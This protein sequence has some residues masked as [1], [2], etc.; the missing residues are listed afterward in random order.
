MNKYET[1]FIMS[2]KITEE[3]KANVIAKITKLISED[4]IIISQEDVG[5]K[6]LA[7]QIHKHTHANYYI[8][9]FESDSSFIRELERNYRIIEEILK[10]IIIRRD[11]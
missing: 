11:N 4:G 9:N 10:F 1:V 8:I 3:Q 6:K 2:N 7:Y 5:E